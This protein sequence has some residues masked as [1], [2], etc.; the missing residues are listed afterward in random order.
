MDTTLTAYTIYIIYTI[1]CIKRFLWNPRTKLP[2]VLK[3]ADVLA[4][5]QIPGE[6]W[7]KRRVLF[8]LRQCGMVCGKEFSFKRNMR[9]NNAR[10]IGSGQKQVF[11][12]CLDR[13]RKRRYYC[14]IVGLCF[15]S[16]WSKSK[17]FFQVMDSFF[18]QFFRMGG[19]AKNIPSSLNMLMT[20][21]QVDILHLHDRKMFTQTNPKIAI[22]KTVNLYTRHERSISQNAALLCSQSNKF[23]VKPH[24]SR[25][26]QKKQQLYSYGWKIGYQTNHKFGCIWTIWSNP[27]INFRWLD[28]KSATKGFPQ[29]DDSHG[30]QPLNPRE[31]DGGHFTAHHIFQILKRSTL[32]PYQNTEWQQQPYYF[33]DL[34]YTGWFISDLLRLKCFQNL[35][36]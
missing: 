7:I 23:F 21:V 6:L 8:W 13:K 20:R 5:K 31:N 30:R 27:I 24:N 9:S 11:F 17:L 12:E 15:D 29:G 4:P 3:G 10:D 19:G 33:T 14:L 36:C 35:I 26:L 1:K 34:Q 25:K 22:P 28:E 2:G 16:S 18:D 32:E